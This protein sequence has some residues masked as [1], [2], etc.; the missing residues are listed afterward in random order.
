MR[1]SFDDADAPTTKRTQYYEM[2]GTRGIWHDGWKASTEHGPMPSNIGH[3]DQDRWQLFHTEVD[4]SEA[5]DL[6]G[7][8]PDKLEEL[9]ALWLQEAEANNVLPLI[10]LSVGEIHALEYKTAIPPSGQYVYYPGTTEIPEAS[11]AGTLGRSFKILAEVELTR[12]SK[13]V[14]VAQCSRFGG[15]TLFLTDT[16]AVFVYNFLGIPP[17]Q[18]VAGPRPE[19]GR[20]IIGVEFAKESMSEQLECLGMLTLHIDDQ[21]VASLPI[22]TQAGHYA[23][24]GEGL[25]VSYDSGDRVSAEY[26]GRNRFTNGEIIQVVYDVADDAYADLE[27]RFA[28]VLARD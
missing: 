15:Y 24:A 1:Y 16:E 26:Q 2:V 18:R 10:D 25:C 6:A 7:E 22:R 8:F 17:E 28:A 3:F 9:K 21:A 5:H 23:L 12:D 14:I 20:H 11:A 27:L 4:R 13:G 19:P